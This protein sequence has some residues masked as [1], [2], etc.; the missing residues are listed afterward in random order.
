MNEKL[1]SI[2][3]PFFNRIEYLEK[4]LYSAI[5]QTYK[6]KEI[7]LVNDASTQCVEK[8]K[9]IKESNKNIHLI[10]NKK[11]FGVSYSR[12]IGIKFAKGEY[13]AFLDSDDEWISNK[14]EYQM[15]YIQEN[16]IDFLYGSYLKR[17]LPSNKLIKINVPKSYKMPLMA[18]KCKIATPTV[19]F[20]KEI[21][22][23]IKFDPKIKFAE[24]IIFWSKIS[25]NTPLRGLNIPLTIVNVSSYS[26]SQ[27]IANQIEGYLNINKE[28]FRKH[29]LISI[30]HYLYFNFKL[31]IKY[32]IQIV[33]S[34]K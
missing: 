14:I 1:V 5:N 33:L 2:I 19:I 13:I 9:K 3:I 6:N 21:L 11:N 26:S 15:K 31:L 7:I 12:N 20:K 24:D 10:N 8:I 28:L 25:K 27:N 32:S 17:Y 16:N 30:L 29:S 23:N 22:R 34:I 4:A 18:F